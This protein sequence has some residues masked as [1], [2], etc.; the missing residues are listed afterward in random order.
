MT[1]EFRAA[2]EHGQQA[3][4]VYDPQKQRLHAAE[5]R[6]DSIV[7]CLAAAALALWTLGYPDQA[8][9][10]IHQAGAFAREAAL[11]YGLVFALFATAALHQYRREARAAQEQAEE[12]IALS[13]EHGLALA[14]GIGIILRGWALTEQGQVE[15]GT[16]LLSEGITAFQA[17]GATVITSYFLGLLAGAYAKGGQVAEGL[18]T[19][20]QALK[21]ADTNKTPVLSW[22]RQRE[23]QHDT[24]CSTRL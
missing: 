11:P 12:V 9:E 2:Y 13:T 23:L 20:A 1:G 5:Y 16:G 24:S 6:Q 21:F 15:E 19:V 22:L 7:P 14:S 4:R 17:T 18:A 10:G 3:L 8:L